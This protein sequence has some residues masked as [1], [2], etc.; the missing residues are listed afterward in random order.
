[1][2]ATSTLARWLV[3]IWILIFLIVLVVVRLLT[4]VVVAGWILVTL[5]V[6]WFRQKNTKQLLT[7][8]VVLR[9][10][11]SGIEPGVDIPSPRLG[12]I[13]GFFQTFQR[14]IGVASVGGLW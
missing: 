6:H 10:S 2:V 5:G 11:I 12:I 1:L 8:R 4:L 9:F 13:L 3:I 7:Q 14:R